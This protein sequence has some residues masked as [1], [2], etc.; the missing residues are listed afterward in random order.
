MGTI[1]DIQKQE[2]EERQKPFIAVR[3]FWT[4]YVQKEDG[5][6]IAE[7]WVSWVKKGQSIQ[8]EMRSKIKFMAKYYCL[9]WGYIEPFYKAWKANEDA[10]IDGTPISAWPGASKQIVKVLN[11]VNIRSIDDFCD[12]EDSALSKL[13][14]PG[15]RVKQRECRMF[16]EAQKNSAPQAAKLLKLEEENNYLRNELDE[17]K[18]Q[19]EQVAA[20]SEPKRG[21]GRPRKNPETEAAA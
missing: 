8:D 9:E 3:E 6:M 17:L 5:T 11:Q 13:A 16:R 15:L 2:A 1:E 20:T 19:I 10:P 7:D 12:M 18:K 21:P 4:D 14:M